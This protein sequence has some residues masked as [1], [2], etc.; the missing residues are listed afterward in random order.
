MKGEGGRR[1]SGRVV[2]GGDGGVGGGVNKGRGRWPWW[3][4]GWSR[5]LG[6]RGRNRGLIFNDL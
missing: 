4:L 1:G 5:L 6:R 2:D 3:E